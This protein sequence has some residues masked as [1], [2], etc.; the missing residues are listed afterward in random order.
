MFSVYQ[1][2][3]TSTVGVQTKK[4]R[5]VTLGMMTIYT[6]TKTHTNPFFDD[7]EFSLSS[8]FDHTLF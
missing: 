1:S 7:F 4:P 3:G 5:V 8:L 6:T 2:T